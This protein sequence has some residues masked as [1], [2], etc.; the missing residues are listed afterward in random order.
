MNEEYDCIVL[1]T[2]LKECILSGILSVEGKKVLHM[3]RN[4][5]YGGES[6]SLNLNQLFEKFFP[7]RKAPENLGA[8]REYNVDIVP[9]FLMATGLMVKFLLKTGVERYLEFQAVQG[10]YVYK[11]RKI[12]RVPTTASEAMSSSLMGLFEKRRC[13]EFLKYVQAY[14]QDELKTHDNFDCASRPMSELYSKFGVDA[15]TQSFVGHALA[16]HFNDNYITRPALETVERIILYRDSLMQYAGKSPYIY[17]RYGLGELPQAFAR[18]AAIYGG[19]YMLDKSIDE[20][21]YDSAGRVSGVRSGD[22][23]ARCKM[24]I[25]DPS[26]FPNKTRRI[27]KVARMIC[28]LDHPISGTN[29]E[30]SI[31]IIIPQREARRQNDIY[32]MCISGDHNV[33]PRGKYIAI[34]STNCETENP[35]AELRLGLDLLGQ[36]QQTF[37]HVCDIYE[38]VTDGRSDGVFITT[39]YDGQSHFETTS[40]DVL[41]VYKRIT[42]HDMDLTPMPKNE[43]Q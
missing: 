4:N 43:E 20:I 42:G 14:K 15:N 18:L 8:T 1:G 31:Q 7:G 5:Y 12:H 27:G 16:L 11:D 37:L 23:T 9:K 6:A 2:G 34:V 40:V 13:A 29:K 30:N 33:A 38:P 22:E 19:T 35:E 24:V 39:S 28:I 32:V 10:S 41:D 3:D 21:L 25:A 26:Y 36:I 17:P